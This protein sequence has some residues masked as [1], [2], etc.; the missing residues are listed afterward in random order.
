LTKDTQTVSGGG[1][2]ISAV[3]LQAAIKRETVTAMDKHIADFIMVFTISYPD[4]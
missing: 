4:L 2:P 1:G 3:P